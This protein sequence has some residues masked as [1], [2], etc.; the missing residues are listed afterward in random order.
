MIP[1]VEEEL[2]KLVAEGIIEQVLFAD[3]AVPI[4]PVLKQ[5]KVSVRICGFFKLTICSVR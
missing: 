5:D 2:D 3:W 4:V 1:L